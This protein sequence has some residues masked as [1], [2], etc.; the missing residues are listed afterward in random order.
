MMAVQET[1]W[2][3]EAIIDVKTHTLLHIGQNT[4]RR[5][6]GVSFRVDSRCKEVFQ[7]RLLLPS[8]GLVEPKIFWTWIWRQDAPPECLLTNW[9]DIL[10]QKTGIFF[11]TKN[12]TSCKRFFSFKSIENLTLPPPNLLSVVVF[13]LLVRKVWHIGEYLHLEHFLITIVFFVSAWWVWAW[14][15]ST[16]VR[17]FTVKCI[18]L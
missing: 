13:I 1:T 2:Q 15:R 10:S 18:L 3:G 9:R 7:R 6:F 8:L 4:G 12:L 17:Q 5:V 11:I 14:K 16:T